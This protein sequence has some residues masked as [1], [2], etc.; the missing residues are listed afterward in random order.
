MVTSDASASADLRFRDLGT[1][2]VEHAGVPVPLGGG[3]LM[4]ALSLLLIDAG[5]HVGSPALMAAMWGDVPRSPSTLDSH[6]WRLR[7]ALE[8][9]R[10]RGAPSEVLLHE[11]GGYRLVVNPGSVDSLRFAR[12]ADDARALLAD[13]RAAQARDR[14][15]EALAL[16]RGRPFAPL[17]DE[18]W[19]AAAVARLQE[20]RDQ[21]RELHVEALLT[22]GA[23]DRALLELETAVAD[24]PL[25]EPLWALRM[26]AQYQLGRA[27]EA[28]TTYRQ[29]R[30]LLA[31]ELGIEPGP[32]LRDLQTRIL[33]DGAGPARLPAPRAAEAEAAAGP[34]EV[35]LP[36]R[37]SPIVGRTDELAA[38]STLVTTTPLV[39]LV[40]AAGCGKTRLAIEVARAATPAFDGGVYFVD[41]T[42]AT[43]ADQLLSAVST[44][45]GLA[46]EVSDNPRDALAAVVRARRLLLV[47]DNC[48]Q[49]L[50]PVAELVE[51]WL[52][53]PGGPAVLATSREALEIWG[54]HVH[55]VGPLPLPTGDDDVTG[56]PAVSLLLDRLAAAGADVADLGVIG[57]AV[58]IAGA[59]DGVPLA[60]ELAAARVRAFSLD[61]IA[62]QVRTDPSSLARIGRGSDHH[63]TVRAAIEQSYA[64]LPAD[65]AAV[66][67]SVSVLPGPFTVAAAHAVTGGARA[68][69]RDVMARL[70]HR[71]LLVPL[72]PDRPGGPSRFSQLATVRGHAAHA[73]GDGVAARERRDDWVCEA[74]R[75]K[76]RLG[77]AAES[78]WFD[79]LDDD[80]PT[81]R[82]TLQ[83]LL[84][85]SPGPAG[86]ELVARLGPYWYFR[87][88]GIE[89]RTWAERALGLED[90]A[91]PL[92]AALVRLTLAHHLAAA[93]RVDLAEPHLDRAFALLDDT[94]AGTSRVVA[95][96]AMLL[97][98]SLFVADAADRG[99]EVGAR[100]AAAAAAADDP[101]L[102]LLADTCDAMAAGSAGDLT[103]VDPGELH[104]RAVMLGNLHVAL[105]VSGIGVIAAI[106]AGDVATGLE[107]SDRMIG[108]RLALGTSDGPVALE[109]RAVLA[110]MAGDH[111]EAVR[112]FAAARAHA[113]RN[114]LRWPAVDGS[115]PLLDRA[116]ASL[117]GGDA[118]RARAE[119]ARL[120]LA[121]VGRPRERRGR[122]PG[123]GARC[124]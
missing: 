110:A 6:V 8:P 103:G 11:T 120:T 94:G 100:V 87:S 30:D 71:S 32:Q 84:V 2:E 97:A 38:L 80:L 98:H 39:T 108:H 99:R 85:D 40:G 49:V 117:S 124:G 79:A 45:L 59:V 77:H 112:L 76:P 23:P 68:D 26:L 64:M 15:E 89:G 19:A 74:V 17:S 107:W 50:D 27:D 116:A 37:V 35:R 57:Q 41:L 63:R 70:V 10:S 13:G 101:D 21:V 123:C 92:P 106:R 9:G 61:E 1:L 86:V 3:R 29:V 65:E 95:E 53:V 81:L 105:L 109:L 4:A 115:G 36:H 12:L 5:R 28:L 69:V 72:G 118:D 48:E 121:D 54:E 90:V 83:H 78:A 111:H 24:N 119:G 67:R 51:D 114:G 52:D 42:A 104:E 82:A 88:K 25:R 34:A 43:D 56:S 33:R 62:H 16:W 102:R 93:D 44:T 55:P 22:T 14:A 46:A 75:T 58:T 60:L 20:Q 66:H 31:E 122:R 91:D 7:K 73:A 47:L 113:L 96:A 18:E